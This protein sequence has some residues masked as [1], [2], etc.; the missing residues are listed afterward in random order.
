[1]LEVAMTVAGDDDGE[2]DEGKLRAVLSA[3]IAQMLP[4]LKEVDQLVWRMVVRVMDDIGMPADED[5][6]EARQKL[7]ALLAAA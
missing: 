3:P 5:E 2:V 7:G 4:E 6:R 1:M